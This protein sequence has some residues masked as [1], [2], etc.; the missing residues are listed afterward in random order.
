M[1]PRHFLAVAALAAF[2]VAPIAAWSCNAAGS[3]T[4]VGKLMAVD[5]EINSFT[6]RDAESHGAIT[7]ISD[8]TLIKALKDIKGMV[9]VRYQ[10]EGHELRAIDVAY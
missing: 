2:L 6:I 3:N 9:Q 10:K 1:D 5:I 8:D 7:F 4:H